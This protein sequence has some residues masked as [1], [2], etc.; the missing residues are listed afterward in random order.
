[1]KS[2]IDNLERSE[3]IIATLLWYG[4]WLASVIIAI[5]MALNALRPLEVSLSA[6]FSSYNIVKI[7]V[8]LFI[9]LPVARV[10]LMLAI[11]LRERD[12]AYAAISAL[13]LVT[14][15]AGIVIGL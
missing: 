15:A 13:V 14:I 9:L 12:F 3:E 4:T 8:A 6:C 2:P 1:M 10:V 5:G 11:F 7:G